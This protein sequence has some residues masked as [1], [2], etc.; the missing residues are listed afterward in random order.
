MPQQGGFSRLSWPAEIHDGVVLPQRFEGGVDGTRDEHFL[1]NF[2][3]ECK[4]TK[5]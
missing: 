1:V 2:K 4:F 5:K 3:F